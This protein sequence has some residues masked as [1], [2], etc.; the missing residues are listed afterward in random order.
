MSWAHSREVALV[1]WAQMRGQLAMRHEGGP[2][3]L[4]W[5]YDHSVEHALRAAA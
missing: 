4:R 3:R 5:L 1:L 2:Q